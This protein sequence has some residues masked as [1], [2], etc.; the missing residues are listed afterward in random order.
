MSVKVY[1][2]SSS[3]SSSSSSCFSAAAILMFFLVLFSMSSF[4]L[5]DAKLHSHS[6]PSPPDAGGA[7][8]PS[9][10]PPRH[11]RMGNTTVGKTGT[12]SFSDPPYT[13]SACLEDKEPKN[14]MIAAANPELFRNGKACG[15]VFQVTCTGAGPGSDDH[16]QSLTMKKGRSPPPEPSSPCKKGGKPV[17]VTVI[18]SCSPTKKDPCPTLVLSKEAF[19]A[20]ANPDAGLITISFQPLQKGNMA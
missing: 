19:A 15:Q 9:V 16:Q 4:Q 11:G 13:P 10:K 12:A 14:V 18:D 5:V 8:T 1:G 6:P 20:I 2:N 17:A 7:P 3:S